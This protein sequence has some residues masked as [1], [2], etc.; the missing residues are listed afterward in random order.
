MKTIKID[1]PT[2]HEENDLCIVSYSITLEEHGETKKKRELWYG[3]PREYQAFISSEVADA[4]VVLLLSYAMRG[5]YDI[6]CGLPLSDKLYYQVTTQLMP[7]LVF[8]NACHFPKI[9][10]STVD[11][12]WTPREVATA[13]S[14]GV[15]SFTTLHEYTD[16]NVSEKRRISCV[17]FFE[18]GAHHSGHVGHSDRENMVFNAQLKHIKS[19][20][21][22]NQLKLISITSNLDEFLTDMFWEDSFDNTFTYRNVSFV[23]LLQKLIRIYYFA[24]D[25]IEKDMSFDLNQSSASYQ[26]FLLASFSTGSTSFLN[27]NQVLTRIE[28]IKY[29]SQFPDTYDSLLVCY[30]SDR[31]CGECIKC[32][33]TLV[34][35]DVAGVLDK[36]EKSFDLERYRK[37]RSRFFSWCIA[38]RDTSPLLNEIDVYIKENN[39]SV[40]KNTYLFAE[41][42]RIGEKTGLIYLAYKLSGKSKKSNV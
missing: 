8:S 40:P 2:I 41:L 5:G 15:D 28:K 31:N 19:Y 33:R 10:A 29:I 7:Q 14:C 13:L 36:Y 35:M 18:N 17:T 38:N 22:A 16:E 3:I 25:E 27:S 20:C 11:I 24:P 32:R 1:I 12:C 21:D 4:P 30:C 9:T 39:I 34:E 6:E 23:L 37:N 26:R 42:R